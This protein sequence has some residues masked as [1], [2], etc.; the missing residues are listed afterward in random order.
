MI[1]EK[2]FADAK[3]YDKLIA[4]FFTSDGCN[5]CDKLFEKVSA[6]S[7]IKQKYYLFKF[8]AIEYLQYSVRLTRGVIPTISVVNPKGQLLAIIE[9][10]NEDYIE[11]K[12]KEIYYGRN[13]LKPLEYQEPKELEEVNPID[14]Y[15][16]INY[17]LDGNPIDFRTVEFL[18]F[19]SSIHKEYERVLNIMKPADPLAKYLL[20]G[21]K[22]Q[23]DYTYTSNIAISI[24]LGI[25]ETVK[26]ELIKR[27]DENGKVYRS[28]RKEVKGLLI[29]EALAGEA[30]ITLYERTFDET[31]LNMAK[32]IAEYIDKALST[33]IGFRDSENED[34]ITSYIVYEPLANSEASIF[35]ARLWAVTDDEKYRESSK[36]AMNISYTL[37]D[38]I[39]VLSRIAISYIKLNELIKA[40]K[41]VQDLRVEVVKDNGC[42]DEELRYK[43]NNCYKDI[44]EIKSVL[45]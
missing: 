11:D 44:N 28:N 3:F 10:T 36:K 9:S 31:Y 24:V 19:Y 42:P 29:D 37:G 7:I 6:M 15:D 25:D 33:P 18:K 27:I 5:E 4:I 14:F 20:T 34:L 32:K 45:L 39:R 12:L 40:K 2:T 35:F 21:E 22:P 13:K 1:P 26:D 41:P 43:D 16:I 30:L 23:L 17:T 8:N 38:D